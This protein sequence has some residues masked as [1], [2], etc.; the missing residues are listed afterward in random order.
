MVLSGCT[1]FGPH[2]VAP[3]RFNYNQAIAASANE[4][5]LLNLVR[6]R[7]Q[8]VPVFLVVGSVL[9]QYVYSGNAGINAAAG[10]AAGAAADSVGL[11]AGVLYIERPT[12]TYNPLTGEDFS[13]QLLTPIPSDLIF[14]LIQ[15]GWRADQLLAMSLQRINGVV[16]VPTEGP[17]G[18]YDPAARKKFERMIELTMLLSRRGVIEMQADSSDGSN[19]R[20]LVFEDA[21]DAATR[22]LINE[23]KALLQLDRSR[24]IYRVTEQ[25]AR[26]ETDE[27]TIRVRSILTLMRFLATGV[28][29]P[30]ALRSHSWRPAKI[31]SDGGAAAVDSPLKIHASEDPP[32]AAFV[33]VRYHDYWY[34]IKETDQESKQAF[35]LLTYL[36]QLQSPKAPTQGPVLTVPT[37]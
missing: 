32:K 10:T 34:Y 6:L 5:M 15:S 26:R 14:S 1:A 22:S 20:Y 36:F 23:Y 7:Y 24:S 13:R 37:G 2:R 27:V 19:T 25:L 29:V 28:D 21:E 4:Q 9:T 16:N 12:I 35:S 30:A 17:F 8:D 11:S 3:D 18:G 31:G 33:A